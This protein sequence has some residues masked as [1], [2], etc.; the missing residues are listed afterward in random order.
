MQTFDILADIQLS[1]SYYRQAAFR[2]LDFSPLA[3]TA[4]FMSSHTIRFIRDHGRT[5]LVAPV[6]KTDRGL[7]P[8]HHIPMPF[9]LL[10]WVHTSNLFL[11]NISLLPEC[12]TGEIPLFSNRNCR[13]GLT[14]LNTGLAVQLC[15]QYKKISRAEWAGHMPED[16]SGNLRPVDLLE[17]TDHIT[18]DLSGLEPDLYRVETHAGMQ[19]FCNRA[20][21]FG[22]APAALLHI[23]CNSSLVQEGILRQPRYTLHIESPTLFWRYIFPRQNLDRFGDTRF[24]VESSDNSVAFVQD[25]AS[26]T[27]F[28]SFT[29]QTPIRLED[30]K[31]QR[32]RL[33]EAGRNGN[34]GTIL[35]PDLPLPDPSTLI[36]RQADPMI[37]TIYVKL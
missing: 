24:M 23:G 21:G 3:G 36:S 9:S 14:D 22:V 37:G 13:A 17:D 11:G 5:Q 30:A 33:K 26:G 16:S 31:P 19:Y 8:A 6:E 20:A 35:I 12:R 1:H 7:R 25:E 32:F 34:P 15:G 29:S 28:I 10:F 2:D 4:A 27:P 18:L